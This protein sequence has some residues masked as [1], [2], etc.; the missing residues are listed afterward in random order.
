MG[1]I[2]GWYYLIQFACCVSACNFYSDQ[3]RLSPCLRNDGSFVE[4]G[5]QASA[6]YDAAIKLAG[7]FH[8]M[9]WVRTTILLVVI[10]LGVNLMHVWYLSAFTCLYALGVFGYLHLVYL[11]ADG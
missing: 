10:C 11:S 2:T 6:V 3:S 5:N 7:V 8:V 4:A 9:E 1:G